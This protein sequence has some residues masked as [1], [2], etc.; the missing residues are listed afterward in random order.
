MRYF[1]KYRGQGKTGMPPKRNS[2][3]TGDQLQIPLTQKRGKLPPE[4]G[5]NLLPNFGGDRRTGEGNFVIFPPSS[6]IS[7][8]E[9]SQALYLRGV[10]GGSNGFDLSFCIFP[11]FAVFGRVS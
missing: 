9:A 2:L 10:G 5:E 4:Q 7:S 6:G 1:S 3:K 11:C 8:S